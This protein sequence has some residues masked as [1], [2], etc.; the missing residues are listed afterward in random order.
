M[1][2]R[3]ACVALFFS[4]VGLAHTPARAGLPVAPAPREVRPDGS[5]DPVPRSEPV[6]AENPAVTVERIITN[7]KSVGDKLEK[8]DTGADTR[9]TQTKILSDIDALINQQENPPPPKPDQDKSD[10]PQDK[11]DKPQDKKGGQKDNTGSPEKKN[12]MGG[13]SPKSD[14]P[15]PKDGMNQP[16][17]P[18]EGGMGPDRSDS[19]P[20]GTG[21]RRPRMGDPMNDPK[22][23]PGGQQNKPGNDTKEAGKE[24]KAS[25]DSKPQGDPAVKLPDGLMG[26]ASGKGVLPFEEEDASKNVWGHLPDKLRRQMSQYYKEEFTPKYA[27]LLRLYYSS[28]ADKN[29][30]PNEPKK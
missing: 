18:K 7:S 19:Q 2:N 8:K 5:R 26:K 12:D 29:A 10:K 1:K 4:A 24:P 23:E 11:S 30:K 15:M 20:M 3:F 16:P 28:L 14:A 13:M 22:Q 17:M 25:K 27:E 6:K 21:E 9:K